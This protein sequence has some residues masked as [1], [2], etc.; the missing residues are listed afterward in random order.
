MIFD[1]VLQVNI[2]LD[3]SGRLERWALDDFQGLA[4]TVEPGKRLYM[5]FRARVFHTPVHAVHRMVGRGPSPYPCRTIVELWLTHWRFTGSDAGWRKIKEGI[6]VPLFWADMRMRLVPSV[7]PLVLTLVKHD[8]KFDL[9]HL[10]IGDRV[11][12][13][14]RLTIHR[15]WIDVQLA[16]DSPINRV[17]KQKKGIRNEC[18]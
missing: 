5:D 18:A 1:E 17:G 14:S 2:N 3:Y 13:T 15:Y 9:E 7:E 16:Q 10:S 8:K 6:Q 4:G 12:F 11:E